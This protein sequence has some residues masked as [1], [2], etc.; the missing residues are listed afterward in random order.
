MRLKDRAVLRRLVWTLVVGPIGVVL[1]VLAVANRHS[2]RLV[3]DPFSRQD[4]SVSVDAP[5][6]LFLFAAVV[7]GVLLGGLA[8][9]VSQGKWR[10]TARQRSREAAEWHQEA[11][12]LNR[13]ME[14]SARAQLPQAAGTD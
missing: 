1:V 5:F 12:R 6:F 7:A 14:A 4:P 3:L 11:D 2:V 8:T 10:K 9:W 13:Q